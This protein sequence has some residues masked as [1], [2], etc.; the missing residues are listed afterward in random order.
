[1]QNYIG[2][3]CKHTKTYKVYFRMLVYVVVPYIELRLRPFVK[4]TKDE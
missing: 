4:S 1:M 3:P 2:K